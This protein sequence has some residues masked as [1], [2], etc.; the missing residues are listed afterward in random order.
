MTDES[1]CR[2][3]IETQM[4]GT[5]VWTQRVAESGWG[6]RGDWDG[7]MRTAVCETDT[8]WEAAL[9]HRE[10][11][12]VLYCDLDEWEG[13]GGGGRDVQEGGD[14]CTHL[15]DSLCCTAE[16]NTTLQSSYTPIFKNVSSIVK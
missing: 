4:Q 10:L 15:A 6:K 1:I 2:A 12:S 16:T 14:I 5:D 9:E 8:W 7:W 13:G 3:G 11:S